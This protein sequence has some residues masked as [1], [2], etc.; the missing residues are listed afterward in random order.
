MRS[1]ERDKVDTSTRQTF[2]VLVPMMSVL[3]YIHT[4]RDSFS[5]EHLSHMCLSTLERG[6]AP[7]RFV[8]EIAPRNRSYVCTEALSGMVFAPTQKLS[9]ALQREF[10]MIN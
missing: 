2:T 5:C 9:I 3:G 6:A 8:T 10:F 4:M 1:D 7:R